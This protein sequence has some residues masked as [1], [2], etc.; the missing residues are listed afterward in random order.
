MIE[1]LDRSKMFETLPVINWRPGMSSRPF[2]ECN[3]DLELPT[4]L[5]LIGLSQ[6]RETMIEFGVNSGRTARVILDHF[7]FLRYIGVDVLPGYQ[8]ISPVQRHEVPENAGEFVRG[9]LSFQ[10]RLSRRGSLDLTCDDLPPADVVFIDG[11]HSAEGVWND[12]TLAYEIVRPGG[13]VIWH[14][15]KQWHRPGVPCDVFTVLAELSE[16]GHKISHVGD[17]WLAFERI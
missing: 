9:D 5:A 11:D 15:Y 7:Q 14:D 3:D 6:R 17:S 2:M 10:L 4:L 16:R 1:T 12:S 8:T 13:L